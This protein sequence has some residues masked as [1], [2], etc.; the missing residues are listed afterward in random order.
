MSRR[1]ILLAALIWCGSSE[2]G[3]AIEPAP[4]LVTGE[5]SEPVTDSRG[6]AVRGRLVIG[7]KW[8]GDLRETP[9]YIELQDAGDSITEVK[10]LY[11]DLGKHDFRPEYSGGLR[12]ELRDSDGQL[13]EY[14]FL[15]FSGAVPQSQWVSLPAEGQIRLRASPF[16]IR[17]AEG[18]A[19]CP[20]L[21]QH[22]II[23]GN[24][25]YALSG[26]FTIDPAAEV[27]TPSDGHVWRG[28]LV[29]P[30]VKLVP[31]TD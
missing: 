17:R 9:L 14:A 8:V 15:S 12:C 2:A 7:E 5:W 30:A 3:H 13:V 24:Q 4:V 26:T 1:G 10:Q 6:F 21:G 31:Q 11:C 27:P 22:W 25:E 19:I 28:T 18:M 23:S 16:G 29:L 20:H